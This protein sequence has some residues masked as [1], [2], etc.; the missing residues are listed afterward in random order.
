MDQQTLQNIRLAIGLAQGLLLYW[1]YVTIDAKSWPA[2]SPEVFATFLTVSVFVPLIAIAGLG[3]LPARKLG[4][5][6]VVSAALCAALG[7]YDLHHLPEELYQTPPRILPTYSLLALA[8]ILFITHTIVVAGESDQRWLASYPTHF[9]VAWK[10]AIQAALAALFVGVLWIVLFLGD[11]LFQLVKI[12]FVH[13]LILRPLFSLP[14]TALGTA[15]ALHLTDVRTDIVCGART[16]LLTLMSWLLPVMTAFGAAFIF[17]LPFT[18][19]ESLWSTK[20]ATGTLLGAS[21]C[22]IVLINASYQDGKLESA[23]V[24][25]YCRPIAAVLLLPLAGLAI[26]G[27]TLRVSQYGWSPSRV[28]SAACIAVALWYAVGYL[29]AVIRSG[30]SLQKLELTNLSAAFAICILLVSLSTPIADPLRISVNSQLARLV[31]KRVSFDDFD[32]DFLRF[33]SGR[34]GMETLRNL[35]TITGR[36]DVPEAS[37]VAARA[38]N[39]LDRSRPNIRVAIPKPPPAAERLGNVTVFYP[40]GHDFPEGLLQQDWTEIPQARQLPGCL[41][42]VLKCEAA[43]ID[44]DGDGNEEILLF[45]SPGGR[46]SAFKL[47]KDNQWILLGQLN[48]THCRGLRDNLTK[49][50]VEAVAPPLKEVLIAGRRLQVVPDCPP[51]P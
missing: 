51:A 17:T 48:N 32:Y 11:A 36:S 3:H 27:L 38:R 18:G 1:L 41:I 43:F 7:F 8:A 10:H 12:N 19:L 28:I 30:L 15:Y 44:L 4:T 2:T 37:S 23:T 33:G 26:Y 25:R 31:D 50:T 20:L 39:A 42:G 22:L 21:A 16:L 5:W 9:D 14:V 45:Q 49:G 35:A 13:D 34:Y 40:Q 46:A 6:L 24:L 47:A 29:Y